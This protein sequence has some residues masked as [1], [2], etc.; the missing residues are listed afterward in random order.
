MRAGLLLFCAGFLGCRAADLP[1]AADDMTVAAARDLAAG[2]AADQAVQRDLPLCG[3]G[4]ACNA[5][6]QCQSGAGCCSCGPFARA[7]IP[8]W[9]CAQPAANDPRC[10][11]AEPTYLGACALPD[12][13]ACWYCAGTAPRVASCVGAALWS[14]CLATGAA[15]C[16]GL[17]GPTRGCD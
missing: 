4:S 17:A 14:E 12:G 2:G 9:T 16:W 5:G 1:P 3:G 13:V 7:C 10:P 8:G 15:R 11:A 6:E